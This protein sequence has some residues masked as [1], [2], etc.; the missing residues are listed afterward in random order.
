[1]TK[2]FTEFLREQATKRSAETEANRRIINEWRSAVE[3]LFGDIRNW[4]AESDPDGVI[5]IVPLKHQ[6]NEPGLGR[7]TVPRLDLRFFGNWAGFIPKARLTV[8]AA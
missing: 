5:E 8:A 6:V 2:Q 7:Y 4:L 3:G 1:M